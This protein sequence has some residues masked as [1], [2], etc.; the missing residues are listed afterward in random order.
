[1]K[2]PWSRAGS[3]TGLSGQ[4]DAAA[5]GE[6]VQKCPGLGKVLEKIG[7]IDK[8]EVL[9]LGP[10]CGDTAVYFGERGARISVAELEPPPPPPP[11]AERDP[12]DLA[13]RT[14]EP[15][16]VPPIRLAFDDSRF[17]LVLVWEMCDFLPPDRVGEFGAELHRVMADGGTALLMSASDPPKDG[18]HADRAPRYRVVDEGHVER[19]AGSGPR[20]RRYGHNPRALE[21]ALA[22]LGVASIHLQRN[23]LREFIFQKKRAVG[24]KR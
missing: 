2:F 5:G 17:D 4:P 16:A 10:F 11:P 22:P 23:Q 24:P 9:D 19:Q 7:R 1:M 8:P 3:S 21:R 12:D 20:R 13:A 15:P 18:P 14:S 6:A